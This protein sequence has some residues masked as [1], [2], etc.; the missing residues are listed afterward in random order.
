MHTQPVGLTAVAAREARNRAVRRI[1]V[2]TFVANISVVFAKGAAGVLANSLSVIADAAHSSV[3]AWNNVMALFLA[4]IAAKA[5]DE[6]HPYGHA[7]FETLGALAIVAFLSVTVYELVTGAILRL[8]GRGAI[9][10]GTPFAIAVMLVSAIVN[11]FVARY[12]SAAGRRLFS[13]ILIADAAHTRSDVYASLAVVAGLLLVRTGY[14]KADALCTL[15][16]AI[17]IARAGWRILRSTVPILVDERAVSEGTIRMLACNTAG[18]HDCFDVRSRGR[19]GE[20]F[21]E[22]TITV[23]RSLNVEQAHHIAD[24]VERRIARTV[25]AREVVVHVEPDVTGQ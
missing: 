17:V 19:A 13:E 2:L 8:S 11:F 14:P 16:V 20:I 3:D 1:L 23:D 9:P 25:G 18:V 15:F 12:E 10:E 22:L 6:E 7:K 24:E 4:R 21:A 5:P